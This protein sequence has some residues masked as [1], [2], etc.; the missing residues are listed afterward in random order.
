MYFLFYLGNTQPFIGTLET[1]NHHPEGSDPWS[2]L[3]KE[4]SLARAHTT[5]TLREKPTT[6]YL[7]YMYSR[8]PSTRRHSELATAATAVTAKPEKRP[9]SHPAPTFW[10]LPWERSNS[11]GADLPITD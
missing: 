5:T 1:D 8:L 9:L 4:D 6:S 3:A 7:M 11:S 2:P 10:Q